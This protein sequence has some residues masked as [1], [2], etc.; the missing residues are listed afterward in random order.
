MKR[1][2][3]EN[4]A[5]AILLWVLWLGPFDAQNQM[6][7]TV[8]I[9]YLDRGSGIAAR[10]EVN[11]GETLAQASALIAGQKHFRVWTKLLHQLLEVGLRHRFRQI[12]DTDGACIVTATHRSTESALRLAL[13]DVRRHILAGFVGGRRF[14]LSWS[15]RFHWFI[16]RGTLVRT[17]HGPM[18]ALADT[19]LGNVL[20]G[21]QRTLYL[22]LLL[23]VRHELHEDVFRYHRRL[24]IR[25]RPVG[26]RVTE[27]LQILPA[28]HTLRHHHLADLVRAH[29]L[30]LLVVIVVLVLGH[31]LLTVFNHL[32]GRWQ[33][34]WI[35]FDIIG[36]GG[37][38][39]V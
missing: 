16:V 28:G 27:L 39:I 29:N 11:V 37:L 4:I 30:H 14:R 24:W 20:H 8:T 10:T 5:S 25:A 26:H 31:N 33:R 21:I 35:R 34:I 19:T 22:L 23:L 15:S 2:E 38:D 7:I 12:R 13:L 6:I 3:S 36:P 32:G 9:E 17:L 1:R 18:L